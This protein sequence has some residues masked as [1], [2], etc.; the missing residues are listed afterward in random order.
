M[1]K[2]K[3][4]VE[5]KYDFDLFF[6]K[7]DEFADSSN[8]GYSIE[9]ENGQIV[10]NFEIL[11]YLPIYF[12]VSEEK[13]VVDVQTCYF[14]LGFHLLVLDFFKEFFEFLKC[15]FTIIDETNFINDKDVKKLRYLFE[16]FVS[17]RCKFIF[18]NKDDLRAKS[19]FIDNQK[20]FAVTQEDFVLTYTGAIS[21]NEFEK[22]YQEGID[23]VC[24]RIFV[25]DK[26]VN[27]AF[28]TEN[29][30]LYHVWNSL[31]DLTLV[32][33]FDERL[34]LAMFM[35]DNIIENNIKIHLPQKYAREIY[36]YLAVDKFSASNFLYRKVKY[37]IGYHNY[38]K[39]IKNLD[40]NLLIPPFYSYNSK[41]DA[42]TTMDNAIFLYQYSNIYNV[43]FD[44]NYIAKGENFKI[45]IDDTVNKGKFFLG[46]TDSYD[47]YGYVT[48]DE[49]EKNV[50]E[51]TNVRIFDDS[52]NKLYEINVLGTD[53]KEIIEHMIKLI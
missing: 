13:I 2:F 15:K 37:E 9:E 18:D 19:I 5:F 40:I 53:S 34:S 52:K 44:N 27:D 22:L 48:I 23:K 45:F 47:D 31:K 20:T 21:F 41:L 32:D 7:I 24:K 26:N 11:P 29:Y 4:K 38:D 28:R 6:D 51:E 1:K 39:V 8:Y 12:N 49:Q 25:F 16:D 10:V 35:F 46:F 43:D 42:Y 30:L 50:C 14:G 3:I 36:K 17:E 33:D